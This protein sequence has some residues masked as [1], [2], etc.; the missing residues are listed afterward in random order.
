MH[1]SSD[2]VHVSRVELYFIA[3]SSEL[4]LATSKSS[5]RAEAEAAWL[6]LYQD[7]GLPIHV[8]RLGGNTAAW[9]SELML[10]LQHLRWVLRTSTN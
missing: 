5:Q 7:H 6:R 1:L 9:T 3:C 2:E 10:Q 4:R 8:F